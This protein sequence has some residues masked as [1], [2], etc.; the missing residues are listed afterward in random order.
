MVIRHLVPLSRPFVQSACYAMVQIAGACGLLHWGMQAN[1]LIIMAGS[2]INNRRIWRKPLNETGK[3]IEIYVDADACPVKQEVY[4]VAERLGL[5]VYV[6]SNSFMQIPREPYI[7][8]VIVESGPDAADDW[9]AE[10]ARRG[11][12]V[13]TADIPLAHR[14][15]KAS[16]DV[17]SP[18]GRILEEA[19]IGMALAT[20]N[21]MEDLRSAG[22]ITSGPKPFQPRDRSNFLSSLDLVITRLKRDGFG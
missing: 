7:E 1:N 11:A 20:R 2:L 13:I 14:C 21:L 12:V 18:T 4:R 8:R 19:S 16:A 10:R 9:I 6:V 22:Q 5:K 17:I 3:S 15:V